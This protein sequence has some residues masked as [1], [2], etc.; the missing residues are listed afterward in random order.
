[1]VSLTCP[2]VQPSPVHPKVVRGDK[3]VEQFTGDT[4]TRCRQHY[5]V[6][7]RSDS[8]TPHETNYKYCI[9]DKMHDDYG[10]TQAW[11]D[12]LVERLRDPKEFN[13]LYKTVSPSVGS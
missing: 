9:Y 8:A 6:R 12:F 3:E 5:K 2:N 7:P 1:M 10:Y 11:I 4:H 13:S